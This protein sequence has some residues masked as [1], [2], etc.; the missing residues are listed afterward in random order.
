M[1]AVVDINKNIYKIKN[2]NTQNSK[3][4]LKNFEK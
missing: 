2:N 3:E 1:L 4:K